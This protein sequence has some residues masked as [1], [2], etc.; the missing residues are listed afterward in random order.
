[1]KKIDL[2]I[3]ML[4][5]L[6]FSI[7]AQTTNNSASSSSTTETKEKRKV[8]RATKDQITQAQKMLKGKGKYAGA[9]DG[10]YNVDLRASV[11]IFQGENNL[12]KSGSLNRATLEKMGIVL[13]D[14]QK[15]IPVNPN[16][17]SSGDDKSTETK[18]SPIFRATKDQITQVQTKLKTG[19]IYAGEA[20]GKLDD[21][22]RGA[23]IKWQSANGVKPTGTLNKETLEKMGIELTEKQKTM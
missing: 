20:T 2:L 1:M 18:R 12:R 10:K 15:E 22:T 17:L 11:K 21:P 23:I 14:T 8:F 5:L 13:T 19:G 9:E 7:Q 3:L 6:A 4:I 16:D